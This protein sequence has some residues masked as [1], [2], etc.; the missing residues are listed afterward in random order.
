MAS[1]D[2]TKVL[3]PT[4]TKFA[5]TSDTI[6]TNVITD[7]DSVVTVGQK[8]QRI[9][10]GY[11]VDGKYADVTD[12][13]PLPTIDV[14][15]KALLVHNK[16]MA[17]AIEHILIQNQITNHHLAKINGESFIESDLDNPIKE[18]N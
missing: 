14:A 7:S 18:G 11:G 4:K 6:A 2:G 9:K 15:L 16:A 3:D 5:G 1:G 10:T 12:D 17:L 8:V 13:V